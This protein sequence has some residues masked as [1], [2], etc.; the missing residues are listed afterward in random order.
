M[1]KFDKPWYTSRSDIYEGSINHIGDFTITIPRESLKAGGDIAEIRINLDK[2]HTYFCY[3][4]LYF[5]KSEQFISPIY[6]SNF[7][8][9]FLNNIREK[10]GLDDVRLE[11]NEFGVNIVY[12]FQVDSNYRL[13][14]SACKTRL[15]MISN[16]L[17][18]LNNARYFKIK[19]HF[20]FF[21]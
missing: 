12:S 19:G 14:L 5:P 17:T 4:N 6:K 10:S 3:L 1:F 9:K 8:A 18:K 13:R 21:K 15:G 20:I 16:A 7:D 11:C 2:D